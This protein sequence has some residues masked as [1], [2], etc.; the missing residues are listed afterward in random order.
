MHCTPYER[1]TQLDQKLYY[2]FPDFAAFSSS[3]FFSSVCHFLVN[4]LLSSCHPWY[5][6]SA[7][8][9]SAPTSKRAR[10]LDSYWSITD[11]RID[12]RAFCPG[13]YSTINAPVVLPESL[14]VITTTTIFISLPKNH[15][16]N[17]CI[18]HESEIFANALNLFLLVVLLV[19]L[20]QFGL[21]GLRIYLSG[22]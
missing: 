22:G 1:A 5:I 10:S 19:P 6:S 12:G 9:R 4:T 17:T 16:S 8:S 14:S 3:T 13:M 2:A 20:F 11:R 18:C 21:S 7:G 15:V